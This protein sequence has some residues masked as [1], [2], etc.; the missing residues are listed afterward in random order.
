MA[1]KLD[2]ILNAQTSTP[3]QTV[4]LPTNSD[5]FEDITE[6]K[7]GTIVC[8][9]D[10]LFSYSSGQPVFICAADTII[11]E[12]GSDVSVPCYIISANMVFKAP[13]TGTAEVGHSYVIAEGGAGLGV[14]VQEN[15][16]GA[17]V[18]EQVSATEVRCIIG[19]YPS[20]SME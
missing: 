4:Y 13:H 12:D 9:A 7:A 19:K 8:F 18:I 5:N 11:P 3:E 15:G 10:C 6:I 2:K 14:A 1:F 17:L 16:W 20:G